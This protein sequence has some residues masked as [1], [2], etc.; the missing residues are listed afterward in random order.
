MGRTPNIEAHHDLRERFIAR[1]HVVK[2]TP[3]IKSHMSP[4]EARKRGFTE[5]QRLGN[6][7][8]DELAKLGAKGH[9]Y[10]AAQKSLAKRAIGLIT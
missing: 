2:K 4:E 9:G 8:A 10:S 5:D 7:G 3:W 1:A 6:E